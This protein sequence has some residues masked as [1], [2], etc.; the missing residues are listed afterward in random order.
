MLLSQKI[1]PA[2]FT[3]LCLKSPC[4]VGTACQVSSEIYGG[5]F[6][7]GITLIRPIFHSSNV[8]VQTGFHSTIHPQSNTFVTGG[9]VKG[10]G[11]SKLNDSPGQL[12]IPLR[13]LVEEL[14]QN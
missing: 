3:C 10:T 4:P 8:V 9:K 2:R 1:T 5:F 6:Y 11:D 13:Y 14:L 12:I 7:C